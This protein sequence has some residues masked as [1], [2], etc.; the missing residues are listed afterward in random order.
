VTTSE[1]TEEGQT[2]IDLLFNTDL[3]SP[4]FFV[5]PLSGLKYDL[6]EYFHAELV[7][8]LRVVNYG[9]SD[10]VIRINS[11]CGWPCRAYPHRS[12][13]RPDEGVWHSIRVPIRELVENG[14]DLSRISN[15]L[16]LQF[17]GEATQGLH[18]QLNNIRWEYQGEDSGELPQGCTESQCTLFEDGADEEFGVPASFELWEDNSAFLYYGGSPDSSH[19]EWTVVETGEPGFGRVMEV[20]FNGNDPGDLVNTNGWFGVAADANPEATADLSRFAQGAL[21]FDMRILQNG[22]EPG[23]LEFHMEC[24]WPCQAAELPVSEPAVSGQWQSYVFPI[25]QLIASGL[26]ITRVNHLFVFK[27]TWNLQTGQYI[28]QLDNIRLVT[29][30]EADV[31]TD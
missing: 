18:L 29:D 24:G 16:F 30:Y 13:G 28:I 31:A 22:A 21:R 14:L 9:N 27:P 25:E 10:G 3:P 11:F 15:P 19:V 6:T 2:Y 7:F 26:D 20:R 17:H 23:R 5:Y 4:Q 1:I 12:I 8:D